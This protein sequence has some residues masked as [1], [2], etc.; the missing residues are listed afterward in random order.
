MQSLEVLEVTVKER[1][2]VV[3]LDLERNGSGIERID[4]IDLEGLGF[5]LHAVDNSLNDEDMLAPLMRGQRLS[6]PLGP[7]CFPAT[8]PE[9][10]FK[11]DSRG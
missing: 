5:F 6:E 7:L 9:D 8:R 4:V 10:L 2:F 1:I 3:P 11:R